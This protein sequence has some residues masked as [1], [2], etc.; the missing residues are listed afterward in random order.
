MFGEPVTLTG[1][2]GLLVSAAGV[3][4]VLHARRALTAQPLGPTVGRT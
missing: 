3:W 1:L 2:L 4:L